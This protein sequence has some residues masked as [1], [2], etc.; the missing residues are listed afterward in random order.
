MGAFHSAFVSLRRLVRQNDVHILL[1]GPDG[2]GK[3]TIL[4]KLSTGGAST[5]IMTIG[6]SVETIKYK[7]IKYDLWETGSHSGVSMLR[8]F[9]DAIILVIDST[10]LESVSTAKTDMSRY[11]PEEHLKGI[12][13]LVLATKQDLPTAADVSVITKRLE[14][15]SKGGVEWLIYPCSGLT[16]EGLGEGLEWLMN[17]L[18][19]LRRTGKARY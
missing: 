5:T 16:G 14:F 15:T 8:C 13:L 17:T 9:A 1:F 2:A 3:T 18:K 11:F 10:D 19:R 6:V 7:K 12:P 4:H